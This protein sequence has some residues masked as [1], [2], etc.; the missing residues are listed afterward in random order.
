MRE[1]QRLIDEHFSVPHN[2]S[3]SVTQATKYESRKKL[4][5]NGERLEKKDLTSLDKN[6]QLKF[7]FMVSVE[8]F[9]ITEN[10]WL[11]TIYLLHNRNHYAST[12]GIHF[13][14]SMGQFIFYAGFCCRRPL[15]LRRRERCTYREGTERFRCNTKMFC[16]SVE[17]EVFGLPWP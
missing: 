11:F 2:D 13:M 5:G 16:F 3:Q 12:F 15:A 7:T 6:E 8:T 14:L 4:N 1:Y 9:W 17:A 10:W